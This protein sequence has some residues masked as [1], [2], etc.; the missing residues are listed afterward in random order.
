MADVLLF[1]V[2]IPLL[3]GLLILALPAQARG[4]IRAVGLV[5]AL[6]PACFSFAAYLAFDKQTT[7]LQFPFTATWMSIA[8]AYNML[9]LHINFAFGVDGIS[10]P[11]VVLVGVISTLTM[12]R[13][14][15][16]TERV[17]SHYFWMLFLTMGLYGVFA[18]A[19][20]FTFFF[21]LE[22][23]LVASYL[24][25]HIWG[26]EMRHYAATKFLI[27]R[28]LASVVLLAGLIGLA[29]AYATTAQV[30]SSSVL[31]PNAPNFLTLSISQ[32]LTEAKLIHIPAGTQNVLF[33][34]FLLAVLMEEAFVPFHTWLPDAHEHSDTGTNMMIGGAL[35]KIGLYVLLRFAVSLLPLGLAH[36]ALWLAVFG[37]IS[38]LYGAI[39]A[40]AS[41]DWRRLIAF[42]SISHMG[43][44]L[45]AIGSMQEIGIQGAVF[46]LVSSGLLTA[47]LF[48]TVGAQ[49]D[50]TGT[51]KIENLG[52]LSKSLPVISGV[53]LVAA[54][55]S[56][57]LPGL[58]GFISEFSLF[59][60]GFA[61]FPTLSALATLGMIFAAFYLLWA[62]QR[63]TFGP[64]N[65]ALPVMTDANA[66]EMVPM[67]ILVALVVLI[68]VFPGVLGDV[69]HGTAQAIAARI[70]G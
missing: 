45:L 23:T 21:F 52:G 67:V 65:T 42:S 13:S 29:Y 44:V 40:V 16:V 18:A 6:I 10:M 70:G 20:L 19:D 59:V 3:A 60:G 43:L 63:T 66:V 35:M 26:G 64:V 37:V 31:I 27:Y 50:R 15:K 9:T 12:I 38:I 4:I 69:V 33:L 5:G 51:F 48:I 25:I 61:V 47:L 1:I 34:V 8:N 36:Y 41:K 32:L 49:A 62:M 58:S 24:L 54:L 57:G 28:G 22:S 11:L 46:M 56:V 2:L 53:M 68:G 39:V 7:D 55:G 30:A 14:F 17:K